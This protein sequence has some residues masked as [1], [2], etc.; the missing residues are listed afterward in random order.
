MTAGRILILSVDRDDDIGYKAGVTSPVVGREACLDAATR[1]GIADPEDS[2]TNAIFQAIKTYDELK[3]KGEDVE[4]AVI[5]GNHMNMLEGDRRIAELLEDL[6]AQTGVESCVLISDGAEDEFVLPIIQSHLKVAGVV[7][8][9]IKQLPNI[10]GTYYIIKKLF[11]DPKISRSVLVP[12]ALAMILYVA[13]SLLSPEIPAMLVVIGII[14]VYL[15]IKGFDLDEYV[16]YIYYGFVDSFHK[17]RISFVAYAIAG[18]LTLCGVIAGLMSIVTYYPVTGDAGLLYNVMT[19]LYGAVVWMVVAGLVAVAGKIADC[20][21][22]ER[23][24]LARMFVVPFFIVALGMIVYGA[25]IYFLSISP[26]EPFPFT[27]TEGVIAII[28]LTL[29][30][31]I[32]AFTGIYYRP[33]VQR[34]VLAWIDRKMRQ[35]KEDEEKTHA[36]VYKKI[37]Y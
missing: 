33:L 12:I 28:L 31:L 18:I 15:L 9:V 4:V 21:Q 29:A 16:G 2:D 35:D 19:F 14:G 1:L 36:P 13:A 17:G 32:V 37:K 23:A 10:E 25:V 5:G 22:N 6:V 26:I 20:V 11:N 27:T 7:R 24:A 3:G 30:G 8:V 34:Y